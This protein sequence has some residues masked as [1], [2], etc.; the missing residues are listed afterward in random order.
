LFRGALLVLLLPGGLAAAESAA[1]EDVIRLPEFKVFETRPLPPRESWDYVSVGN[2]E[3]LSNAP[4]RTTRQFARD[5]V[6]FQS[7]LQ[8]VAPTM[9]IRAE[10]PVMIVLCGKD[11]HYD[12]FV[13]DAETAARRVKNVSFVRDVEI[14]SIVVDYERKTMAVPDSDM[15]TTGPNGEQRSAPAGLL[16]G[17][18][19]VLT[20]AEFSRQYVLLSLSEMNPR[21]P[22]WAAEGLATV[23]GA[24]EYTD[25]WIEIGSP[26][27]FAR[28]AEE[29]MVTA[30]MYSEINAQQNRVGGVG[31]RSSERDFGSGVMPPTVIAIQRPLSLL[32]MEELFLVGYDSA[33]HGGTAPDSA[34]AGYRWRQQ[35]AAFVH[36]CLYG[37]NGKFRSAFIKF[38]SRTSSEPP[39]EALFKECFG[40]DYRAMALRIRGHWTDGEFKGSRIESKQGGLLGSTE[41]PTI[42]PATDAEIGRIKGETFRLTGQEEPARQEFITAYLRGER[43]LQ[44]LASLGLM[45]RQR[46]DETRARTYLNAVGAATTSIPRPRAYLELARLRAETMRASTAVPRYNP[47]A[48]VALLTPLFRAQRLPQQLSLIYRE[49][50]AVWAHSKTPPDREH[51]AAIEHGARLFPYDAELATELAELLADRGF[52]A[53]AQP[54]VERALKLTRDPDLRAR[55][56]KLQAKS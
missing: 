55:L 41:T 17:E 5:L 3:I 45:A 48:V 51:L 26:R 47:E 52:R 23:Y 6:R 25:K 19:P 7:M 49:I 32:T 4:A 50:A 39:T 22:A 37:A 42:R 31:W 15:V 12:R 10:H 33:I 20:M 14:A 44:L 46:Q 30:N 18:R 40:I 28:Q 35:C 11:G 9:L 43:D 29:V 34:Y 38:A 1:I 54:H 2:I 8:T 27:L 16:N 56:L 24:I 53:D 21:L 36:L 13:R